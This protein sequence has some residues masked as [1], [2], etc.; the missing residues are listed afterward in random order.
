MLYRSGFIHILARPPPEG[1]ICLHDVFTLDSSP[2]L[3]KTSA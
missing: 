1:K 3:R 2:M